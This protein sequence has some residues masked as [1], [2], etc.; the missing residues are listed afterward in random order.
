[1]KKIFKR[2]MCLLLITFLLSMLYALIFGNVMTDFLSLIRMG[3]II[4]YHHTCILISGIPLML[5]TTF[6][7]VRVLFSNDL[8][9]KALPDP[10]EGWVLGTGALFF[11]YRLY[12]KLYCP[13]FI[14]GI[15]ISLLP[16]GQPSLLSCD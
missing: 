4:T 8:Q 12:C 7:M 6:A 2:L 14:S 3:D 15:V 11:C 9:Y 10:F 5:Y 16:A 1:M 13:V